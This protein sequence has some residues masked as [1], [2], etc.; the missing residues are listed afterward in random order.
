MAHDFRESDMDKKTL[1]RIKGRARYSRRDFLRQAGAG[2]AAASAPWIIP[3]SALAQGKRP[4]ANDRVHVALFGMGMRGK[5]WVDNIPEIGLIT[6]VADPDRKKAEQFL[7][8]DEANAML[9]PPRR[10]GYELP[11]TG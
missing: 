8:D 11:K 5:Q 3:R 2:A 1:L 6:A 9:N 10:K 7:D 4:G